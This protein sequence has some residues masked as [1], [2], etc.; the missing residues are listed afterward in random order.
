MYVFK[1]PPIKQGFTSRRGFH[2]NR[3]AERAI[4]IIENARLAEII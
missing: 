4:S 2:F 1:D 3:V